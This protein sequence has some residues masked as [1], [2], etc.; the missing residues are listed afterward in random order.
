MLGLGNPGGSL[1]QD[2]YASLMEMSVR[3]KELQEETENDND[4]EDEEEAEDEDDEESLD[5]DE[6]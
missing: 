1:L 4:E 2:S 3:L 5:D 6:V